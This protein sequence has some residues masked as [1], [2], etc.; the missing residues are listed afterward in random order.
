MTTQTSKQLAQETPTTTT[1]ITLYEGSVASNTIISSLK[2]CNTDTDANATASCRVFHNA[3]G[4]NYDT[5]NAIYYDKTVNAKQTISLD[6]GALN[7]AGSIGVRSSSAN[8]LT[9]TLYGTETTA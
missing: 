5:T 7:G 9:F 1:A 8:A 4:T 2:V 6:A 3:A